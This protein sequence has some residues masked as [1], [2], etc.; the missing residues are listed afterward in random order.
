MAGLKDI[1]RDWTSLSAFEIDHLHRLVAE[2]QVFADLSF[3]DLLLVVRRRDGRLVVAAQARPH[4][5]QTI[6]RDDQVGREARPEEAAGVTRAFLERRIVREG[7]PVWE[8]DLPV[9][10]EYVPV[11]CGPNYVGAVV[12]AT[13]LSFARVPG[14]LES[15]YLE[16]AAELAA[17][18]AE[19]SFPYPAEAVERE[20]APRVGDGLL[21]LDAEGRVV[22]GSPNA[23]SAYRRLGVSQ[24]VTGEFLK[25]VGID[26]EPILESLKA[27]MPCE[28]EVESGGTVVLKRLL[29]LLS[30][31]RVTGALLLVRDVSELR[32]RERMLLVKDATIREIHHRVKNNLQM[33]AS[34]LRLQKRRL[35]SQEAREALEESVRR[36]TSIA[37][38][39]E[40]LSEDARESVDFDRVLRRMTAAVV[41]GMTSREEPVRVEVL[42]RAGELPAAVATPLALVVSELVQNSLQH[43]LAGRAGEV[44]VSVTRGPSWLHLVVEDDGVGLPPDFTLER[45]ARL[46]LQIVRT[47]V[48]GELGGTLV[49]VRAEGGRTRAEVHLPS[50]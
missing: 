29:P 19:G 16:A 12:R 36:I 26:E 34:L 8:G 9:R 7:D 10:K 30:R 42:G 3:A 14:Q 44:L 22:Y 25:E 1:L 47:L 48:E 24:N 46:G 4:P 35:T 11:R 17:M 6:Y 13:A 45:G 15:T 50:I 23:V 32:Q 27:G 2:W 28:T 5:A 18:I 38:V 21:K 49:L 39:H 41:E 40:T 20:M 37:L 31:G 33:V 43:G